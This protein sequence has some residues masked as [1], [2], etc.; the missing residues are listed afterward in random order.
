MKKKLLQYGISICAGA[1]I[2]YWV[3]ETEGLFLASGWPIDTLMMI[4]C[5]AFF[6]PGI[7]LSLL[8]ALV[9][10]ASTGFFDALGY[11]LHVASHILIPI[12]KNEYD[13]YYDFKEAR[14]EKRSATPYFLIF[15]GLGFLAVSLVFL[16]LWIYL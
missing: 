10:I 14:A 13:T 4:L 16:L 11:A 7:F 5:D 12:L 6:V 1:L 3:L 8:G 15:V 2:A 9:W